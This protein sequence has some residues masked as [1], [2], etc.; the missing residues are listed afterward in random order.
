MSITGTDWPSS[1]VSFKNVTTANKIFVIGKGVSGDGGFGCSINSKKIALASYTIDSAVL[2][3][4][5]VLNM[6]KKEL[7]NISTGYFCCYAGMGA[8]CNIYATW[9]E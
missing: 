9:Y 2:T 6:A 4:G 1:G 5:N 7:S 8:T 3:G